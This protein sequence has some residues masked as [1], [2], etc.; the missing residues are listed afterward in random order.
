MSIAQNEVSNNW[1]HH[2]GEIHWATPAIMVW[3]SGENRVAN[4]LIHN[5]P[6]SAITVSTRSGWNR[7]Q[8]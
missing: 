6:Y 8:A 3:Q 7:A 1:I 2:T 5:T 4:N